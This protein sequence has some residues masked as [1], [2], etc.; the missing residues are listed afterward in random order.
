MDVRRVVLVSP[1]GYCAGVEAAV[2]TLAWTVVLYDPPVYCV[3]AIVHNEDVVARFERLGVVFVDDVDDVPAG[4]TVVLSAHGS[5]PDVVQRA[6]RRADVVVDAVCPLV[7]K[8]HRELRARL[9]AGDTVL[10]AGRAGH[11]EAEGTLAIDSTVELVESPHDLAAVR[12]PSTRV[13]LLSQT[14]LSEHEWSAFVQEAHD[15]FLSVWTPPT[16]DLCFA[17]TNRQ[18]ALQRAAGS[19][20]TTIVVGSAS[21]SN[22]ASLVTIARELC[23]NV[24]RVG[25]PEEIPPGVG[26]DVAVTAGASTPESAVRAVVEHLAP[27]DDVEELVVT[28]ETNQFALPRPVR[29]SLRTRHEAGA[30]PRALAEAACDPGLAADVLLDLVES[31]VARSGPNR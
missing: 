24:H 6:R 7:T 28:D 18:R 25:G 4:G 26:G 31:E 13:A 29:E 2:K 20:D 5:A 14:T 30:L 17:T 15:R 9:A 12:P 8:V 3:H 19:C 11:D 10:Y 23:A 1:R 22:V 27:S 16:A 21:S